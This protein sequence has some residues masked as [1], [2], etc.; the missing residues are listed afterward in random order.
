MAIKAGFAGKVFWKVD[1]ISVTG[2][3]AELKLLRDVQ[4]ESS[5]TEIDASSRASVFKKTIAGQLDNSWEFEALYDM[6][7]DGI[8]AFQQAYM[9]RSIMAV[10]I[11][12]GPNTTGT[13]GWH[14][15]VAVL[16][17]TKSEPLDGVQTVTIMVKP[18]PSNTEPAWITVV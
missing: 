16:K 4:V 3:Y 17:F 9:N 7:D 5:A 15:D 14:M 13:Q 2:T 6:S 10:K 8:E 18:T 12:D 11:L 1:Q